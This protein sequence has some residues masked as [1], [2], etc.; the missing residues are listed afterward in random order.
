M[1]KKSIIQEYLGDRVVGGQLSE[2][3]TYADLFARMQD[4]IFLLDPLSYQVLE[5]NP[6]AA[7]FLGVSLEALSGEEFLRF[8]HEGDATRA[9]NE[10]ERAASS[11]KADTFFDL[12]AKNGQG[13]ERVLEILACRLKLKDYTEVLQLIARDV[14]EVRLAKKAL[15]SANH[16]LSR[17]SLTDEM[18][19]LTNFRGFREALEKEHAR[20][21]RAKQSYAVIFCDVDHFKKYN[22]RNGHPAGDEVLRLVGAILKETVRAHVDQPARYGGEEF[23][24]LCAD[25]DAKKAQEVAE[26][27]RAAVAGFSF[28]FG[29]H[30]PLGCVSISV[31][32][33][34]FPGHGKN[35]GAVLEAADAALYASKQAGRNR[36]SFASPTKA[37]KKSA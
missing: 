20:A 35:P 6:A 7:E 11:A 2:L 10:L 32:V 4:A 34:V 21:S 15:E 13:E 9:K 37:K 14:T 16:Q 26:R 17:L 29:E 18:T 1:G 19:G 33:A 5:G 36:V 8:V 31:G 12:R 23:V 30:Q 28:P 3:A 25:T 27:V 24:V 22:D